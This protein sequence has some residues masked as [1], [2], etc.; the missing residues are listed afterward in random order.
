MNAAV[1]SVDERQRNDVYLQ[2]NKRISV[3]CNDNSKR[4]RIPSNAGDAVD[5]KIPCKKKRKENIYIRFGLSGLG[6]CGIQ[7]SP[8]FLTVMPSYAVAEVVV[9]LQ[10]T[11]SAPLFSLARAPLGTALVF[12]A[13]PLCTPLDTPFACP[14]LSEILASVFT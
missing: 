7:I 12:A 10:G 11:L 1:I 5:D 4:S 13:A 14:F 3:L 2:I 8:R 6:T 9:P